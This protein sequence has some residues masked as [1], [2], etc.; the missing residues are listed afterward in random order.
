SDAVKEPAII[1]AKLA[2]PVEWQSLDDK[3]VEVVIMLAIPEAHQ[4][5]TH[6]KLLSEIAIKLMDDEL[7]QELK[8]EEVPANIIKLFN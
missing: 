8:Q 4:G 2:Q 5:D 3:P 6:L 1:Y 7:V